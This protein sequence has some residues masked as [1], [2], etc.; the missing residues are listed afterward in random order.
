MSFYSS[1]HPSLFSQGKQEPSQHFLVSLFQISSSA[2]ST[3]IAL[4]LFPKV[5][6]EESSICS[7]VLGMTD[8]VGLV[9]IGKDE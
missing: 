4:L 5:P 3:N 7:P 1:P 9:G 2:G 6:S 8:G